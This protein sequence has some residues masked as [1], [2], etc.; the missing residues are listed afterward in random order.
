MSK[1]VVVVAE[2]PRSRYYVDELALAGIEAI[3]EPNPTLALG[4]ATAKNPD[5][6]VI[7]VTG[8]R[9]EWLA[10][11]EHVV[12]MGIKCWVLGSRTCSDSTTERLR[13]LERVA[14]GRLDC[15]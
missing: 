1:L 2:P 9:P 15:S 3:E 12:L 11:I 10:L 6:V 4:I 5:L 13:Q 14:A 7:D 8:D